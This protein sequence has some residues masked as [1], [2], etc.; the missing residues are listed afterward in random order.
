MEN[1]EGLICT[2]IEIIIINTIHF[3]VIEIFVE[4][5]CISFF[6]LQRHTHWTKAEICQAFESPATSK[7][8]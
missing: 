2:K 5:N 4:T 3:L 1:I 6:F 7:N 8:G